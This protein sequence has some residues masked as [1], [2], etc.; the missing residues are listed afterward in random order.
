MTRLHAVPLVAPAPVS[1]RLAELVVATG[2]AQ[3]GADRS[4]AKPISGSW[5]RR[6][7][8]WPRSGQDCRM[9][10]S[11]KVTS[12]DRFFAAF[13]SKGKPGDELGLFNSDTDPNW[14]GF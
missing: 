10:A 1:A 2:V 4:L 9:T 12:V 6:W 14:L 13:S 8:P 5:P 11:G 7:H 3:L